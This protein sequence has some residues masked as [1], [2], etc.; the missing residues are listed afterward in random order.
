MFRRHK[1]LFVQLFI[2]L[3]VILYPGASC[4]FTEVKFESPY[5][6]P[7]DGEWVYVTRVV[8]G[9]T[10]E[11]SGELKVRYIGVDTPETKHPRK[12]VEPYGKE[13][14]AANTRLVDG[15]K[16][17]LVKDVSDT[18]RYGRLLKYV[19]LPDGTFVNLKLVEDGY[20]RVATFPPDVRF[21]DLFL[22]AERK[23]RDGNRGLWGLEE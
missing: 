19:F 12:G 17:L 22:E 16:V 10:I 2:L 14:S 1:K 23:A 11:V 15:R 13:A 9:D 20:A 21:A 4:R 7:E 18:D 8:D 5:V 3:G 6:T